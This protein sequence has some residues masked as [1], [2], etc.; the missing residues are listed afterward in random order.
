MSVENPQ[1]LP[2]FESG[3]SDVARS[4]IKLRNAISVKLQELAD[5]VDDSGVT[6]TEMN[7]A[8]NA[9]IATLVDSS[10]EALNTLNELAS[11]LGD[12]PNFAATITAS[13]GTKASKSANLSD[14]TD[15]PLAR[16]NLGLGDSVTLNENIDLNLSA[17][18]GTIVLNS[19]QYSARYITLKGSLAANVVIEFP[20][21]SG[22]VWELSD[23]TTR[24]GFTI[25]VKKSGGS[26]TLV[27]TGDSPRIF[28]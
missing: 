13:L 9:A 5:L 7:A 19:A 12:D 15:I 23:L 6:T 16:T 20:A 3:E 21:A 1:N 27:T 18:S 25:S 8:I 26:A 17:S 14:L 2:D 28:G 11:A 4:Y 22:R 10:P 24:G